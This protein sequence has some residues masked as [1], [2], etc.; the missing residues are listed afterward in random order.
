M[1]LTKE[2]VRAEL[3]RSK[4]V[5]ELLHYVRLADVKNPPDI[6]FD[7][8]GDFLAFF[9]SKKNELHICLLNSVRHYGIETIPMLH[10]CVDFLM[11]HEHQHLRSTAH[12][13]YQWAIM[14]GTQAFTEYLSETIGGKKQRF[15]KDSDVIAYL[16]G[17]QKKGININYQLVADVIRGVVNS[18]EDGRIERISANKYPGFEK[19]RMMFNGISWRKTIFPGKDQM[20]PI[21]DIQMILCEVCFLAIMQV[22][23]INFKTEYGGEKIYEDVQALMPDIFHGICAPTTQMMAER[24]VAVCRQISPYLLEAALAPQVSSVPNL[25]LLQQ[26]IKEFLE[27]FAEHLEDF[28]LSERDE[29][30]DDSPYNPSVP[31]PDLE[32]TLSDEAYDK[33]MDKLKEKGASDHGIRIKRE[34]PKEEDHDDSGEEDD[35]DSEDSECNGTGT[36]MNTS[37]DSQA[38]EDEPSDRH[39]ETASDSEEA[40][41][42][43]AESNCSTEAGKSA[44]PEDDPEEGCGYASSDGEET[45]D[46]QSLSAPGNCGAGEDGSDGPENEELSNGL[47][48]DE[49][50]D[51]SNES[52]DDSNAGSGSKSSSDDP[53]EEEDECSEG[54]SDGSENTSDRDGGMEQAESDPG[55][56]A[57]ETTDT[58][59]TEE[60]CS[61]QQDNP[62]GKKDRYDDV[63]A[64]LDESVDEQIKKLMEEAANQVCTEIESH[65][66]EMQTFMNDPKFSNVVEGTSEPLT[67]SDVKDVCPVNFREEFRTYLLD[68]DIPVQY[69][70]IGR[71]Y[72]RRDEPFFKNRKRP[73]IRNQKEGLVDPERIYALA[74]NEMDF[75]KREERKDKFDGCIE[76]LVDNSGSMNGKKRTAALIAAGIQEIRYRNHVPLK[77]VAFDY[78]YGTVVHEVIKDWDEQQAHNCCWNFCKHGRSGNGNCDE[79]DIRIS[80]KELLKRPELKKLMILISDGA[81]DDIEDTRRAIAEARRAGIT[82]FGIYIEDGYYSDAETFSYMYQKDF[83]ICPFDEIS[84]NLTVL[85]QKFCK[86]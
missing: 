28:N 6:I 44:D 32:V 41:A 14:Q 19:L 46:E 82:V 66:N 31:M 38:A 86:G 70:Q 13:P 72:N 55:T 81:P 42:F 24:A 78:C 77:I 76:L 68:E 25:E 27:N 59:S 16:N 75:F 85:L 10:A 80:T 21:N 61:S 57:D 4:R 39:E 67:Y 47:G 34:H 50:E 7:L 29:E 12:A 71:T 43:Q 79:H 60:S 26:M 53:S 33:L 22:H 11:R 45:D 84:E 58:Q 36:S 64:H 8:D 9:D 20:N 1:I 5:W 17:L 73:P 54:Q 51:E 65:L 62:G 40:E 83:I 15:R 18:I 69:E 3:Q 48:S 2:E 30:T 74:M 52:S 37:T 49:A 56:Y 35:T 63:S 23:C